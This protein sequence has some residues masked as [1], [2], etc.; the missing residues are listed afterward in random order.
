MKDVSHAY[1]VNMIHRSVYLF[2]RRTANE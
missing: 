2:L 1:A